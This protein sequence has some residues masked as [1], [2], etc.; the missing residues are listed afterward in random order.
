VNND[1]LASALERA[2]RGEVRFDRGTRAVYATDLSIYRQVPIGVVIPRDVE[3]AVATVRLCREHGVPVLP[4]GGGTSLAGQCCNVAIVLDCSKYMTGIRAIDPANKAAVVEPGVINDDLRD[5]A[6]R[7]HLTF[8]PDPA[9]HKYCTIGGMI[10]NNSC[11]VHSVMAGRTSDNVEELD[12]LTYDG[13]RMRVGRTSEDEVDAIVRAGGRR[14]A[15][16]GG[17]RELRDRYAAL[18]RERYPRI[19][20]RVS[21]Y[22]LDEL[23][24]ENGFHV[25]RALVGSE[26]TCVTVLEA[27][28]RLVDSPPARVLVVAGF[29]DAAS[30]GDRVPDAMSFRPIGLEGFE[31][32]VI[33]NMR[34]KGSDPPGSRR[35]PAGRF[36]L[37]IEFGGASPDE[38]RGR[39][40]PLAAHLRNASAC[41]GVRLVTDRGEQR[42]I[43]E[44]RE[45]G[46]GASRVPGVEDAWPS[47]ED[48]AVP[49]E[50]L[51]AY[52]R[53]FATLLRRYDYKWTWYGHFGQGCVHS[54][55]TF[56]LKT[57]SG[58]STF[59]RFMIDAADLV[60]RYGGSL[61][62]EHG[63]GQAKGELL[64]RMFGPELVAAFEEFKRLWD[65]EWKMNPGKVVRPYSL[66]ENLR[67]GAD[68]RPAV[69]NT[70]FKFPE[71]GGSFAAATERCFGVGLCR[72]HEGGT[73]CP[74]YMVTRDEVHTTRGRAHL[75]FEMLKGEEIS[76]GWRDEHVK[77]ALDL[78][79]SCKGCK[80]DC[81]VSVDMATYKAEFLSH[82]WAGRVRPVHAYAFGFIGLWA[83]LAALAPGL[84]NFV[85][86]AP[87]SSELVKRAAGIAPSRDLP[88][89]ARVPFTTWFAGRR[90]RNIGRPRVLLWPD[91]FTNYFHPAI[92]RSAVRVLESAGY[93][94]VL[95]RQPLC[96][97]R[98]LYDYG[99][100]ATAR[101]WLHG[102][103]D[104]L[105]EEIHAGIPVVALEPSCAAVFRDELRNML[106]YDEDARRLSSNTWLLSEFLE[107]H[108]DGWERP[109]L[110]RRALVHAHCHHRAVMTFDAEMRLL[111]SLGLETELLDSGCCGMAGGFGFEAEHVQ[112]SV[113]AG[114][115]V[116]MPAVRRA[117]ADTLIVADGFSCR[118]QIAQLTDR[119]ALHLAQVLDMALRD[120]PHGVRGRP[121]NSRIA[122]EQLATLEPAQIITAAALVGAGVFLARRL[123][124][125]AIA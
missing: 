29:D 117:A 43:W 123:L 70:Y 14:G 122:V 118:E 97:G 17:L 55:I 10:G 108:A 1:G 116:L 31:F 101:S 4:R 32:H 71:D 13:L 72:R 65:P 5:A 2:V 83:R 34:R 114:E 103:I 16:Y 18:I 89:F 69:V 11:G 7:F 80:G 104:T 61:S 113:K 66:D 30:A 100:L 124:S 54:R 46:V 82:Y 125:P 12:V 64:P 59:R 75:L 93:E 74:S 121:E 57:A 26:G 56:D 106:P 53:N 105:A 49:P 76:D 3:D 68:H 84:V 19:P 111:E 6:E 42:Q 41:C 110:R 38:A 15:I 109:R 9:T 40:E 24:P 62:G 50:R 81:P 120:G 20:R 73:M 119:R 79:L 98:P 51:G 85:T 112:V 47:W 102:I 45:G 25:A 22:N 36:W 48:S 63:D 77:D 86:H 67:L 78:C 107:R 94:I 23:L 99:M 35:L 52:L 27:R 87:G 88:R 39:A 60:V 44:I 115:R 91:T 37:L 90:R 28:V 58:V 33:E 21:G 95:P 92:A 8:G 96:C